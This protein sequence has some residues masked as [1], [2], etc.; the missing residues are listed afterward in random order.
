MRT[1]LARHFSADI[2]IRPNRASGY[3]QL[4]QG[5]TRVDEAS[6]LSTSTSCL[7]GQP[8]FYGK[9]IGRVLISLWRGIALFVG[10]ISVR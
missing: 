6:A 9:V 2:P 10:F 4:S 8:C 5:V 7:I 3:E 1:L